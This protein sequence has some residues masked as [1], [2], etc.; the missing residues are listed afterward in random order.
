MQRRKLLKLAGATSALSAI[1]ATTSAGPD[2][3]EKFKRIVKQSSKIRGKAGRDVMQKWLKKQPVKAGFQKYKLPISLGSKPDDVG[4]EKIKDGSVII[5]MGL[6]QSYYNPYVSATLDF[7]YDLQLS[8]GITC[9]TDK[10]SY[11]EN[12]KDAAAMV[13]NTDQYE[14]ISTD[15][16]EATNGTQ[17]V[18]TS[19]PFVTG[20]IGKD[21]GKIG[22]RINDY[23]ASADW[24]DIDA[25]DVFCE[26]ASKRVYAGQ[27]ALFLNRIGN[28]DP[29]E[30]LV[31]GGYDHAYDAG[32]PTVGASLS[33]PA[34]AGVTLSGAN[35][36]IKERKVIRDR[37]GDEIEVKGDETETGP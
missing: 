17:Y 3:L 8:S 14:A 11:G 32:S 22:Y 12:P 33:I 27:A 2:D 24:I 20:T 37:N 34:G 35:T 31:K 1:P 23:Q 9:I 26:S 10:V 21:I 36:N 30:R 25:L 29:S 15:R 16:F 28:W 18:E 4:T 7:Y 19:D 13:W 6:Y 5:D